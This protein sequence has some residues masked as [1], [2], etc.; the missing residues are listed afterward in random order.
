MLL[1]RAMTTWQKIGNERLQLPIFYE[2][3]IALRFEI[4]DPVISTANPVYFRA[5]YLRASYIYHQAAP[6]DTLLWIL[7][8]SADTE[9]DVETLCQRF[10]EITRLPMPTEIYTQ[11]TI[12]ADDEPFTRIF[13]FWDMTKTPPNI[14]RLLQAIIHTDFHGFRELSSAVFF[15]N[16]TDHILYH[17]YDDRGL[18]VVAETKE[19]LTPLYQQF[20]NWLLTYDIKRMQSIFS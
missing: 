7:Y 19:T 10:C 17:L 11:E 2:S 14:D 6:F 20:Q 8:R 3:P 12:A 15:L 18:D 13:L 16:T 5:A 1:E 4:G 9:S